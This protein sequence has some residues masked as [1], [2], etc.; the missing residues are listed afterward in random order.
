V[1]TY[2]VYLKKKKGTYLQWERYFSRFNVCLFELL[3]YLSSFL[4]AG[5]GKRT[6]KP[7]GAH[8]LR[9]G[10][11]S[12]REH[13]CLHFTDQITFPV[14]G[15]TSL[16]T[17]Y[18]NALFHH[19]RRITPINVSSLLC[20][21]RQEEL[22]PKIRTLISAGKT[23]KISKVEDCLH[24]HQTRA[25]QWSN[26]GQFLIPHSAHEHPKLDRGRG[27]QSVYINRYIL[28]LGWG[29]KS[30]LILKTAKIAGTNGISL[31]FLLGKQDN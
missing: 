4:G 11:R 19:L 24:V 31:A 26:D 17:L 29:A 30:V 18:I 25:K 7:F 20:S 6:R 10:D 23:K 9:F 27:C 5:S 12:E 16:D 8:Q 13:G 22:S 14:L 1:R 15:T 21:T 2:F 3:W 28:T